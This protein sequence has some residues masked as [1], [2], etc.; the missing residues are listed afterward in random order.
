MVIHITVDEEVLM[1]FGGGRRSGKT[2]AMRELMALAR[3]HL[4]VAGS[5]ALVRRDKVDE[6]R[7]AGFEFTCRGEAEQ[8]RTWSGEELYCGRCGEVVAK[9]FDKCGCK[10]AR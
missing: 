8:G 1:L 4:M 5:R 6:L 3:T 2:S 9:F 10:G 7:A